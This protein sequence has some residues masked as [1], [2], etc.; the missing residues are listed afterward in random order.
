[1]CVGHLHKGQPVDP[2]QRLADPNDGLKPD[3]T[4]AV[5]DLVVTTESVLYETCCDQCSLDLVGF[6]ST[7]SRLKIDSK[8][9][10]DT[11]SN[12]ALMCVSMLNLCVL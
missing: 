4:S 8:N 7:E 11:V 12:S 6:Y 5:L 2:P 3:H 10:S 9:I 1:M